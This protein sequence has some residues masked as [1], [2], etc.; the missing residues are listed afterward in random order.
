MD[1]KQSDTRE[2]YLAGWDARMNRHEVDDRQG[3]VREHHLGVGMALGAG[4][5]VAVGAGLGAAFGNLAAGIGFGI[6]MG[7]CLGIA[8]G[9]A[10]GNKHAKALQEPW[11]TDGSRH[12]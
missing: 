8:V 11:E 9:S 3:A 12:P 1:K 7:V 10:L 5:G 2:R 4:F 6:A